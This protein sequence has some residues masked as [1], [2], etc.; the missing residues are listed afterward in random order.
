M[1]P[2]AL[3]QWIDPDRPQS[4]S[5]LNR[6]SASQGIPV[7]DPFGAVTDSELPWIARA[8]DPQEVERQLQSRLC[9]HM[10]DS[11][12]F[13]LKA[14]RVMRHKPGRRCMIEYDLSVAL[15]D[16]PLRPFTVLGKMRA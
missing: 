13:S 9:S 10:K 6:D 5:P 4:G 14:I 1:N 15:I 2:P 11:R 12:R 7:S 8:I 16:G 3:L